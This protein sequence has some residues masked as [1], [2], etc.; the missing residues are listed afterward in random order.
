METKKYRGYHETSQTT[1]IL[2][3]ALLTGFIGGL[4]WST[5]ATIMYYFNLSEVSVKAYMVRSWVQAEWTNRWL[6]DVVSIGLISCVSVVVAFVYFLLFRRIHS[7]WLGLLYGLLLWV[8]VFYVFQPVFPNV[9]Q[10]V[11]LNY[12][13]I[14]STICIYALYGTFVGYSISYDYYDTWL[15]EMKALQS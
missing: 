15:K 4:F 12:T 5:L 11:D 7:L 10:L 3:R 2:A 6:A 1:A 14:V 8:L 9:P 13:T